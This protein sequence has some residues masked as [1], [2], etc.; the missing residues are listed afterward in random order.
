M[1]CRGGAEFQGG[2]EAITNRRRLSR[3]GDAD[4]DAGKA[5]IQRRRRGGNEAG[6]GGDFLN[7]SNRSPGVHRTCAGL[8]IFHRFVLF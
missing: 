1:R 3:A 5:D 8:A 6:G 4:A 7:F 2:D